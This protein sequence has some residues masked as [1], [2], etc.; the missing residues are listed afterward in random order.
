MT[1]QS[2]SVPFAP[3][4]RLRSPVVLVFLATF[5]T[6][7]LFAL[8]TDHV[9]EDYYITYRASKNLAT[10]NGLVFNVGDRLHTFTSPLGVLMPAV[11]SLLT[12]NTSDTAALW[13]FRAMSAAALAGAAAIAL[14]LAS[15]SGWGKLAC[16]FLGALFATDAKMLDFTINGM[17]TGFWLL[18]L[19]YALW[20]HFTPGSRQWAHLGAAWAGLMWSRPDSFIYI[21]LLAIA[22]WIFNQPEKTGTTRL[23]MLG[24]F[25]KAG[26]L[27]T[28]LYGPWFAWAWWYYGS[29]VPH[30]IVAK[31]AVSSSL[32]N[33]L[34]V[35]DAVWRMPWWIWQG[36][37]S[38][39]SV[40]L[41][42]YHMFPPWP[43]WMLP[44]GRALATISLLLWLVPKVRME[45]R[46]ASF[47][48]FG[49]AA[50]LSFVPYFPFPWYFPAVTLLAFVALAGAAAQ[51]FNSRFAAL[52]VAG[53]G[54]A[55]IVLAGALWLTTGTARQMK[56]QQELVETGNRRV[57]GEW[58]RE[59]ADPNDTVF[60]EPLGYIGHFSGLKTYDWPGLSSREVVQAAKWLSGDWDPLI[61][62]LEPTWLV[63]RKS[64]EGDLHQVAR[65]LH[66]HL[67]DHVM[68][69]N[70]LPEVQKLDVPGRKLLEFDAH[71]VL[72]RRRSAMRRD[73][74]GYQVSTPFEPSTNYFGGEALR[75]LHAPGIFIAKVPDGAHR[76]T[77]A[78]GFSHGAHEPPTATDGAGFEVFFYDGKD[79]HEL[80]GRWLDPVTSEDHRGVQ[81]VTLELPPTVKP[82]AGRLILQTRPGETWAKD[83]TCWSI[84]KFE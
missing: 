45:V 57:I 8:Y 17:E 69:F 39:E 51:L 55:A 52:R 53:I 16:V 22:C 10:G 72:Y 65:D 56:A 32:R 12:A 79:R 3:L 77:L 59:H 48:F 28:L 49:G 54:G 21:G 84:P 27:T 1:A 83:W 44:F 19:A 9:W 61:R 76:V 30:T 82:G 71:F 47:G 29:P 78:Y 81:H 7:M 5:A 18:F 14:S 73:Y 66:V 25:I 62:F 26:L 40:F 46:V 2:S 70:R 31:G 68:D 64:G 41:P 6:A 20:A 37:T 42:P 23:Q 60:M 67:Y 36:R 4:F 63:M 38:A 15:R 74:D 58:L 43:V 35:L 80:F 24:V 11:A 33:P 75:M 34:G 13:I 50:Y